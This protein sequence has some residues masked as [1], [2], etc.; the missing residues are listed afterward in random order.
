MTAAL[1]CSHTIISN[2]CFVRGQ[3]VCR[4]VVGRTTVVYVSGMQDVSSTA[5]R[6]LAADEAVRCAPDVIDPAV[7]AYISENA[8][9]MFA[10]PS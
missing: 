2:G 8:L 5:F 4:E 9:Y 7:V 1:V 3:A 6:A 10:Q